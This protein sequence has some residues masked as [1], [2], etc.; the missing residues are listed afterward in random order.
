[1]RGEQAATNQALELQVGQAMG[2]HVDAVKKRAIKPKWKVSATSS[3]TS[4]VSIGRADDKNVFVVAG[5]AEGTAEIEFSFRNRR[6]QIPVTVLPREDWE[7]T[8][9]EFAFGG[10][11]GWGGYGGSL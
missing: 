5:V 4:V 8:A 9:E 11:G 6:V 7:P 3:N 1:L 2:I 10:A